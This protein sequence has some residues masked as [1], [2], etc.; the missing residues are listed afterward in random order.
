MTDE[1]FRSEPEILIAEVQQ[2][3]GDAAHA[4]AADAYEMYALDF[5]EHRSGYVC[6]GF[7]FD[8]DRCDSG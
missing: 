8:V 3:F 7:G 6:N 1:A 5:G 2:D 4:D